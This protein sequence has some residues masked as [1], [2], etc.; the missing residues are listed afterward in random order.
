MIRIGTSGW[1]YPEW[2]GTYYPADLP[3]RRQLEHLAARMATVEINGSFYS[4][5]RPTS[6]RSWYART[7]PDFQFA[8]KGNRFVTHVRR[9]RDATVPLANFLGSG[10][11]ELATKLGPLLWQ[12]PP[13]LTFDADVLADFL[14]ALPKDTT[15]AVDLIRQHATMVDDVTQ[16]PRDHRLLRHAVEVRSPTFRS[17]RCFDLLRQHGVALVVA[18]TAGLFPYLDE[19]TADFTYVRLHGATELYVSDYGPGE[20]HDWA[21]KIRD[22]HSYGDVYV[23]FDNTAK[24]AAPHNAEQ[25]AG[26]LGLVPAS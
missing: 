15:A 25:L 10:V 6:Y 8:V 22:W 12:F 18:D 19:H 17:P 23:Y 2:R 16:L 20:L 24:A 14:A 13:S 1:V 26:L 3:Q 4:L 5:R 7:P 11:L 9:L 21:A